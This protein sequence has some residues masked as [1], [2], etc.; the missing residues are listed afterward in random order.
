MGPGWVDQSVN[1]DRGPFPLSV[2]CYLNEAIGTFAPSVTPVTNVARS[3]ALHALV[4]T[5]ATTQELDPEQARVLLRHAEVVVSLASIGH[6]DSPDHPRW[7]PTA[8]GAGQL[9]TRRQSPRL[10][11]HVAAAAASSASEPPDTPG[12]FKSVR[13]S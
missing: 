1:R 2:E 7:F 10:A 3:Y 5:E 6:S 4:M 11:R 13:H 8:H 9:I 12:R